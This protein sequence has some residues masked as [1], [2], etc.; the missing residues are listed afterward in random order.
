MLRRIAKWLIDKLALDLVWGSSDRRVLEEKILP[1]LSSQKSLQRVLFVGCEWYTYGYRKWFSA[2]SYWTLDYN[3][4]KQ[5]FG[6]PQLHIV[7]SMANL[8]AHFEP[9]SLDLIIC[10]GVFGWGLNAPDEI[11][12]AFAAVRRSL[13]GGGLFLLGWND[14]PKRRPVPIESIVALRA[15]SPAILGPL[16]SSQFLCPGRNRHTY[17]LHAKPE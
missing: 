16:G 14:V 7:D 5:V 4:E 10:N 13:R 17:S 2:D 11:E 12:T 6:S 1:W 3:P 9:G 8:G 15:L